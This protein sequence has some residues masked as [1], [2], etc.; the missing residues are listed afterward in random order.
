MFR[1]PFL[2]KDFLLN[3]KTKISFLF[4]FLFL[5]M[6]VFSSNTRIYLDKNW[7]YATE[8]NSETFIPTDTL[9]FVFGNP[10]KKNYEGYIWLKN[11]FILPNE[12]QNEDLALYLGVP[13]IAQE[14]YLN[15]YFIGSS[16][17][18]PPNEFYNGE[19][20]SAYPISKSIL[21]FNETENTLIIKLWINTSGKIGNRPFIDLSSK[22]FSYQ[23]IT[24]LSF[25]EIPFSIL[26]F[27]IFIA[28]LYFFFYIIRPVEASS[29]SFSLITFLSA[30]YLITICYGELPFDF[31]KIISYLTFQKIFNAIVPYC[32]MYF[33]VSFVRD[34]LN[35]KEKAFV[36]FFRRFLLIS[37]IAVTSLS[38][39]MYSFHI[40][41]IICYI[42][43][44]FQF[45]FSS[46]MLVKSIIKKDKNAF[47][48]LTGFSPVLISIIISIIFYNTSLFD[49]TKILIIFGWQ[50]TIFF[51]LCRLLINYVSLFSKIEYINSNLEK[52]IKDKTFELQQANEIL[53]N[54]NIQL[55]SEKNK[56][57]RELE[58]AAN[59]QQNFYTLK[60]TNFKNWEIA[61]YF[62][63]LESV[64]GDLYD[65]YTNN[66]E[67][68]GVGI[69]D[70]SGHGLSSSLVTML[71]KNII[72]QEIA[73]GKDKN[74]TE[75]LDNI[76]NRVILEKGNIENYLTG[77]IGRINNN[78]IEFVN[79]GHPEP[80][81]VHY[82]GQI[83]FLKRENDSQCGVIGIAEFPTNFI[84]TKYILNKGDFI[85]FYTDGVTDCQ[86]EFG[87]YYDKERFISS[88]KNHYTENIKTLAKS[89]KNDLY[90]FIGTTEIKDD[91][92]IFILK[93]KD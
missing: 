62:E 13:K 49:Y 87:T 11:T 4:G 81:I 67:L 34:Y 40:I 60:N 21:H 9:N 93:F 35:M 41:Q 47:Y 3:F 14:T 74:L 88:I 64:S 7:S 80:I 54:N 57:Q 27:L 31:N 43:C 89:L 30:L 91:I 36:K 53:K 48:I 6:P 66:D 19:K 75:I 22:V 26:I 16:G 68:N 8:E 1:Q 56:T 61:L 10:L 5:L 2:F 28:F 86:N 92:T 18:F 20:P 69:F 29:L 73:D 24:N 77:I 72:Q 78:E 65:I 38:K 84:S 42:I 46:T 83:N 55:E 25:S 90:N 39:T 59:V 82:D 63:P 37:T 50:I 79:A 52:L 12:L 76:N 15:G 85:I 45:I 71:V 58:L 51:F 33:S 70:I 23:K 32:A 44:S 17:F